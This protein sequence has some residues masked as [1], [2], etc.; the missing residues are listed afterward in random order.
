MDRRCWLGNRG[1]S[2]LEVVVVAGVLGLSTTVAVSRLN[3]G[4][5]QLDGAHQELVAN[6]RLCRS[7]AIA[8]GMHCQ[9]ALAGSSAYRVERMLPPSA[10]GGAWTADASYSR[11]LPLPTGV[12]LSQTGGAFEFDTRGSLVSTT[13]R[14]V[15]TLTDS[16][17]ARLQRIVLWPSGQVDAG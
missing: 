1:A 8:S 4:T 14:T 7:Q 5:R 12:T 15:L 16:G 10:P 3:A 11:T 13:T 6:L 2:V 17:H 9:I